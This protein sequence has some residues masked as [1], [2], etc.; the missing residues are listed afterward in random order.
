MG[1]SSPMVVID[2]KPYTWEQLGEMVKSL[3]A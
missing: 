3:K 2:V 1:P